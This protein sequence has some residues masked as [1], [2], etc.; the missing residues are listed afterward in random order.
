MIR[1]SWLSKLACGVILFFAL[2][3][4]LDTIDI[5]G[6]AKVGDL[7]PSVLRT[8]ILEALIAVSFAL[9]FVAVSRAQYISHWLLTGSWIFCAIVGCVYFYYDYG[10]LAFYVDL[11]RIDILANWMWAF[12][13]FS[14]VRFSIT[15]GLAYALSLD[16]FDPYS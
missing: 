12:I 8:F 3:Q 9:R 16:E 4:I 10:G 11:R 15:A 2:Y 7:P 1:S 6:P 5:A 13:V 14:A